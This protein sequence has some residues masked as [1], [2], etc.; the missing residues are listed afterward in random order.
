MPS[1]GGSDKLS[2]A[3]SGA[4][5]G[6][7][8]NEPKG[9]EFMLPS[10]P[11]AASGNWA[12]RWADA[13]ETLDSLGIPLGAHRLSILSL[14]TFF[15]AAFVLYWASRMA[16][17]VLTRLI[18][19]NGHLDLSQKAL[20]QK[21]AGLFIVALAGLIG[22]DVLGIDLTALTVFSGAFGLAVGFG[23]QK[24]LGNL[25][26]G[27]ILLMDRS[28]KPGDVIAVGDAV[29]AVSKIGVRAV[30]VITRDGKEF[31]IPNE[32]LMTQTV[33][34][35][36]YSSRNVRLKIPVGVSY[37]CDLGL[38]QRLMIQAAGVAPRVLSEPA[39][40]VWLKTFGDSSVDHEILVW[41]EDPEM[42][43]GNVQSEILNLVWILFKQNGIEIPYPQRDVH[44]VPHP[45]P[46]YEADGELPV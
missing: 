13:M 43:T 34:N 37:N 2:P 31:L 35:W 7:N 30:S 15:I 24:T 9:E 1:C 8:L 40:A 46:L 21:M 29:G 4:K 36:S 32:T 33:E 19:R 27:L 16:Y 42:G 20:V 17:R 38:A 18:L 26:A 44:I 11:L 39:P 28:V 25:I 6:C 23:M 41:I 10:A 5:I 14:L 12:A 3:I 22:I 45:S